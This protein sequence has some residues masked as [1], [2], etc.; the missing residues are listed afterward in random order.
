MRVLVLT[1]M[2]PPQALGGYE[3][4]CRDVIRRW[5]HAGHEVS[6]LTSDVRFGGVTEAED[7]ELD[8]R[9]ELR[10]YWADHVVLDPPPRQRLSMERHNQRALDRCLTELRPDVVSAWAMGAMSLGLLARVGDRGIRAVCV[11]CDE[12]PVYAPAMDAWSR[13]VATRPALAAVVRAGTGLPCRLPDLDRTEVVFV[14]EAMR[15][16]ARAGSAWAFRQ[17][18]VVPSGIDRQE[19]P[20]AV[21]AGDREFGWR[22]LHVGRLDPRKGLDTVVTAL[23]ACPPQATL[24]VVG[25]GDETYRRR[26]EDLVAALALEGRVSFDRCARHE[27]AGRYAAADALVFAPLWDEPFG[28]VPLEAMSC[29]TPVVASPTGG[30]AEFLED[31]ENCVTFATGDASDLARALHRLAG[32]A[33][34]R[35]KLV[36]GGFTTA[37]RYDSDRLASELERLHLDAMRRPEEPGAP[38]SIEPGR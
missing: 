20:A 10:L 26:L 23:A 38:A 11:V 35:E 8:V 21:D 36:H 2:F 34:L 18:T 17:S 32:E 4:W 30:S 37:S 5:R 13:A 14:S 25:G 19:F 31:G 3:L 7:A 29:G 27:L 12:W 33:E 15:A 28:L 9:R 24:A 22:L 6:V 1:N 16:K